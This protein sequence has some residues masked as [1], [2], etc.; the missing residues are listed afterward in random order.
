MPLFYDFRLALLVCLERQHKEYLFSGSDLF[1]F[2]FT[3]TQIIVL[4][5][6]II[7]LTIMG[8]VL[9]A[10]TLFSHLDVQNLI[11]FIFYFMRDILSS[12]E[13]KVQV[14]FS[15][16]NLLSVVVVVVNF[17]HFH[18]FL[19]NHKANFNQIRHKAFLGEGDSSLF[20]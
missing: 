16:Q 8:L 13:P 10:L 18:L 2:F 1:D 3:L 5:I 9:I 6:I 17:S 12:S 19:Q 7:L 14:S 20:K 4:F 15:D 11:I